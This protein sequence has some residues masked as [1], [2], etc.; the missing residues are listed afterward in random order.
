MVSGMAVVLVLVAWLV[1]SD[2]FL[3]ARAAPRPPDNGTRPV[4]TEPTR[5]PT[6][7]EIVEFATTADAYVFAAR[8]DANYGDSTKLRVDGDPEMVSYLRFSVSGIRGQV[9]AVSLRVY[10]LSRVNQGF[11]VRTT[12]ADWG[13]SGVAYESRPTDGEVVGR[14]G[15]IPGTSWVTVTLLPVVSGD[16]EYSFV[17]S[18]ISTTALAMASREAGVELAPTLIVEVAAASA[19]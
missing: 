3:P 16:G 4:A 1:S 8:P 5:S 17:L 11:S 6:S 12:T 19:N 15:P 18:T 10:A 14:S 9:L 2:P 13:E 7:A